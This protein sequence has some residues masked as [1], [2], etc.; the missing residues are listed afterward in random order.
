M[1]LRGTN[2]RLTVLSKGK[3]LTLEE[4][5][6]QAGDEPILV[7][8]CLLGLGTRWDGSARADGTLVSLVKERRLI[9]V[10]PEQLGGLP[11]PRPKSSLTAD[12]RDVAAGKAAVT[13][14]TGADVTEKFLKGAREVAALAEKCGARYAILKE[15]S[16][17]C[18]V[19]LTNVAFE[20]V[21]G[22]GV[23][24]AVLLERGM[25]VFGSP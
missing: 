7:S 22:S 13:S 9:P 4:F 15:K 14:E 1:Q 17:S 12:G 21:A 6:A 2:T 3:V 16:P 8:A 20:T 5:L 18:G 19:T 25:E 11:T 23:A 10:C 24:A